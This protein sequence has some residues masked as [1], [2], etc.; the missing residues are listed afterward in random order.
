LLLCPQEFVPLHQVKAHSRY[1]LKCV[2]SPN[3]EY[4]VTTSADKTAK[5]WNTKSWEVEHV[6]QTRWILYIPPSQ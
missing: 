6:S 5:L 2:F 3:S 4:L 1:L